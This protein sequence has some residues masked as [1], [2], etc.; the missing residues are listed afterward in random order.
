MKEAHLMPRIGARLNNGRK[1]RLWLE[2]LLP[3]DRSSL[4]QFL[5][6]K[7]PS[8]YQVGELGEEK[9]FVYF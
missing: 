1:S 8:R 3:L 9:T 7:N 5:N 6:N 2:S 4:L